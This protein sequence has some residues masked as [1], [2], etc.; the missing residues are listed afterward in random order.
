MQAVAHDL[1]AFHYVQEENIINLAMSYI[2]FIK[3][4][5]ITRTIILAFGLFAN[6]LSL[7]FSLYAA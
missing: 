4:L 3:S 6:C 2:S 7:V 1:S 5:Q